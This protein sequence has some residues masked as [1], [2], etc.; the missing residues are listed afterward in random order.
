M[1]CFFCKKELPSDAK[2]PVCEHCKDE[3][4]DKVKKGAGAVLGTG[5]AAYTFV[6]AGGKELVAKAM[7]FAKDHGEEAL[8]ILHSLTKK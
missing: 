1:D 8:E 2:F 7:T 3:Y 4:I 6:K 5:A